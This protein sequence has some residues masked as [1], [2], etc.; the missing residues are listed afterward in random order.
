MTLPSS[1]A[2][3]YNSIRAEFGSPSS[4]VYLSLYYRGGP[5]TYA[6]PANN[7]ISASAT[8]AMSASYFYGA[9]NKTDYFQGNGNTVNSGG[10]SPVIYKGVGGPAGGSWGDA[11]GKIGST[12]YTFSSFYHE[13]GPGGTQFNMGGGANDPNAVSRLFTAYNTSGNGV[14]ALTTSSVPAAVRS[15]P[16]SSGNYSFFLD[17]L[18]AG[19]ESATNPTVTGSA[20]GI[21]TYFV[22]KAF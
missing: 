7:A 9:K 12:N 3:D 6:V 13:S 10:K 21:A 20:D 8:A 5:Y 4:N 11:V 17:L 1:G 2:L 14:F 22:L 16:N 18:Q 15:Q 19:I